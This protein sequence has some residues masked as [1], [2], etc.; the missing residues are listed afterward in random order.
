MLAGV[1]A[2]TTTETADLYAAQGLVGIGAATEL[3]VWLK[4]ADLPDP[5]DLIANPSGFDW[6]SLNA[7]RAWAALTGVV[8]FATTSGTIKDWKSG[9]GPLAEA[10]DHGHAARCPG[11]HRG[12]PGRRRPSSRSFGCSFTDHGGPFRIAIA[13]SGLQITCQVPRPLL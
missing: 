7:D 13:S 8:A 6:S 4:N 10:A 1:L 9:W 2:Q 11:C 12:S 3:L 5:A